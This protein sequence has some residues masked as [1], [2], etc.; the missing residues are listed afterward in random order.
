MRATTLHI[1]ETVFLSV[2]IPPVP[3][4]HTFNVQ[5]WRHVPQCLFVEL[6]FLGLYSRHVL[7]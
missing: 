2:T 1:Y 4:A 7:D 6:E 5:F 3:K